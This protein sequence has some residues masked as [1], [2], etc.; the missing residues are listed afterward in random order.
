MDRLNRSTVKMC[1]LGILYLLLAACA[2]SQISSSSGGGSTQGSGYAVMQ[3]VTGPTWTRLNVL[4][5][6]DEVLTYRFLQADGSELDAASIR[7]STHE[8]AASKSVVD[9][10]A[11]QGLKPQDHLVLKIEKDGKQVDERR[12]STRASGKKLRFAV[13]SCSDDTYKDEQ[14]KMWAHVLQ[15]KPDYI[16]AIGDNV[17]ADW[18]GNKYLGDASPEQLWNRYVETRQNLDLFRSKDLIPILAV[19]DD[20]DYGQNDGDRR[21]ANQKASA[22]IFKSF[23]PQTGDREP[24][25]QGPGVASQFSFGEQRFLFL[26]DR[27]FRSANL[28][29]VICKTKA[30]SKACQARAK[31]ERGPDPMAKKE[32]E[33]HFGYEQT[34]WVMNQVQEAGSDVVW[35]ISGDQWFGGYSP[36]ESFEGSH[37]S[38]FKKFL[39]SLKNMKSARVAFLSGDRHSSELIGLEKELLGYQSFELVSSPIHAKVFPSNW[40]EFPN[41]RQTAGVASVFNYSLV[42]SEVG[43]HQWNILIRNFK[44]DPAS[45]KVSLG[46]QNNLTIERPI[47]E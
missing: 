16:F 34:R 21:Y 9:E 44:Y 2:S 25:H 8:F 37:P 36:F 28:P 32:P 41:P 24:F 18:T 3:G 22:Q 35:L 6:K 27:S 31:M 5:S 13:V 23:F 15:E 17:Y 11:L 46:F 30:E 19:W 47:A 29:P 4:R 26:D 43:G 33:T 10:I 14:K 39:S 42:E 20:H 45:G 12:F 7:Q 40:V 38:D 1:G